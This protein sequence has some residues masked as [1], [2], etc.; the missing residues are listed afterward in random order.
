MELASTC[1]GLGLAVTVVDMIPPMS[2]LLGRSMAVR[3]VAAA[4]VLGVRTVVSPGGVQLLGEPV[5]WGVQCADGQTLRADVVVSAVGDLPN[6]EWLADSGLALGGGVHVD[7]RCQAADRVFA[8]GDVAAVKDPSS[9]AAYR[10]PTFTNAVEQGRIAALGMLHGRDAPPHEPSRYMWT[11]QFDLDIKMAGAA[12]PIGEPA[13]VEGD[14]DQ[15]V[16]LLAWPDGGSATTL[17]SVNYRVPVARL[18]RGV[19]AIG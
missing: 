7:S 8:A 13:V 15:M 16:A 14:L 5:P 3:V 19:A 2:K 4:E 17:M 18:K 9:T 10:L 6:V 1:R 12:G 11:E